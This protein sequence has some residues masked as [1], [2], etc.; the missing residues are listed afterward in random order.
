MIGEVSLLLSLGLWHEVRGCYK[1]RRIV[2]QVSFANVSSLDVSF[3]ELS[4]V[5]DTKHASAMN[6]NRTFAG[7]ARVMAATTKTVQLSDVRAFMY[8]YDA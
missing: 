4:H 5:V 8:V 3:C 7:Y 6:R 1:T 2:S